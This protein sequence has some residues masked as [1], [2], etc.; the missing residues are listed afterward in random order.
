MKVH[1]REGDIHLLDVR[2][3][4]PFKYGIATMTSTP[5]LFL[6]LRV[7]VDGKLATGISADHLPPKWFTKDPA[8]PIAEET[9][10]MLHVIENAL[11]LAVGMK[12]DTAFEAWLAVLQAQSEWG[13]TERLPPL[14]TQFGASLVE[15][16]L[17]EATCRAAGRPFW[18]L[19]REGGFG[20]RLGAIH[21]SLAG[22]EPGEF[23]KSPPQPSN[24][25]RHTVGLADPL[26]DDEIA[27]SERL[28]DGLPQSLAACIR[29]YGLR[30]FKVK[31]SGDA[32]RD[33]ERLRRVAAVITEHA[34]A[35]CARTIQEKTF[36]L[37]QPGGIELMVRGYFGVSLD[38][39]EQFHA[40]SAF[41]TF[42]EQLR[43][44]DA[45]KDFLGLVRF[46]EQ[47]LHRDVA[48]DPA[49]ARLHDWPD[50]PP[51]SIDESDAELD[52]LPRAL[53]LGYAGTSHKNC[54]GVF[55]SVANVCLLWR[56]A[57]EQP[58]AKVILSG[59]DLANIGPVALLQDLAVCAALGIYGVER[60]GHHY[61]AGLSMFPPDVQEQV[62]RHHGDLYHRSRDGWPTLD[63]RDGAVGVGSLLRAPFGVGFAVP[64]E[65]FLTPEQ[66]RRANPI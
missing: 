45:L 61:F 65:R 23:L 58:G 38:G 44:D 29:T 53:A 21:P 49:A 56:L 5:H 64:V 20:I 52:S 54:K 48:L 39:N 14:L 27:P 34:V 18:Q 17:I 62:L 50:R 1:V 33:V 46:V 57:S 63:V 4:M 6:R 51:I 25:A 12:A 11:R 66:W 7:E 43:R 40:L 22:R 31:V 16:A 42:W 60:N 9:H 30:Q 36:G 8:R 15:R 13:K 10:E 19:L 47:P 28:D 35:P 37:M 41:R 55:K 26:T 2:T 32:G 3:R 59:E 24:G